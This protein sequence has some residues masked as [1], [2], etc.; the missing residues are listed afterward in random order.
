MAKKVSKGKEVQTGR[1]A[2]LVA[3]T[4][5]PRD[6]SKWFMRVWKIYPEKEPMFMQIDIN[7]NENG[8]KGIDPETVGGE[9]A[10]EIE[11]FST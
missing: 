11:V 7:R 8:G 1:R 2:V 4:V 6:P 9:N 3:E 5:S 10:G